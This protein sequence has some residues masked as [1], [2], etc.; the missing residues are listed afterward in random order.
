MTFLR[1]LLVAPETLA[2]VLLAIAVRLFPQI[3]EWI[4]G[5][6]S[7]I[8][9]QYRWLLATPYIPLS[10]YWGRRLLQ[11]NASPSLLQAWPRYPELR[12][13][14]IAA[15]LW[16]ALATIAALVGLF[17]RGGMPDAFAGALAVGGIAIGCLSSISIYIADLHFVP[18]LTKV[19]YD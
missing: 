11:P 13:T 8:D 1:K 18:E 7:G 15:V 16:S 10:L 9:Q 12:S 19:P 5:W 4:N 3:F 17:P 14:V 6:T 2:S